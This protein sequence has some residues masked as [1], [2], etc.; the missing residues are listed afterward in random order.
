MN[1]VKAALIHL[2]I[3]IFVIGLFV[4]IVFFI[5]YPHPFADLASVKNPLYLL[6]LVDVI[7]G[8]LLTLVVYKKYKK[9]LKLDLT[10]IATMQIIALLYGI[11][12]IKEGRPVLVTFHKGEF[13]LL[14][15]KYTKPNELKFEE[16]KPHLFSSPKLAYISRT[17]SLDIY[18]ASKDMVPLDDFETKLLPHSFNTN[19]MKAKFSAKIDRIDDL[20]EK[21]K[22]ENIVY[23]R[24]NKGEVKYFVIYSAT[25]NSIVD[26]LKF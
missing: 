23:F 22:D 6:I 16:L 26:Y 1:K 19:N 12:I 25:Q 3:S 15:E 21:Y 2:L 20:A 10:L 8:P 24:L 13:H 5:W 17:D 9:Y 18:N 11:Y 4:Y 7:I 14:V